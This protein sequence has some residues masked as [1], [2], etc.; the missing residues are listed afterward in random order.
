MPLQ[1]VYYYINAGNKMRSDDLTKES[2]SVNIRDKGNQ[3]LAEAL[4]D[5]EGGALASGFQPEVQAATEEGQKNLLE[6][7]HASTVQKP[8]K[9]KGQSSEK[10]EKAVPQTLDESMTQSDKKKSKLEP[11]KVL[12]LYYAVTSST[13]VRVPIDILS[14]S[15]IWIVWL[16]SPIEILLYSYFDEEE[17]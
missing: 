8:K 1:E 5:P 4:I 11:G 17:P 15:H 14:M 16:L 13:K 10:T 7:L 9:G 2:A 12:I 6:A 3:E